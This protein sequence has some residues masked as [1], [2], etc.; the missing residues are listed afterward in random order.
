MNLSR[1]RP[2]FSLWAWLVLVGYMLTA[3][4]GIDGASTTRE[5]VLGGTVSVIV[6]LV[7]GLAFLGLGRIDLA[8]ASRPPLRWTFVGLALV[9][10]AFGRP[11]L[12][13]TL[14]HAFGID[15][16]ATP[17]AV[18]VALNLLVIACGTLLIYA[19]RSAIRRNVAG[20]RRLLAVLGQL[21]SQAEQIE[22]A[23]DAIADDFQREVR[24]PVLDALGA[25]ASRDLPPAQLAE[26]LRFVAH[27][28]V[29]PLSHQA[30]RAELEEALDEIALDATPTPEAGRLERGLLQPSRIIVAPAWLTTLVCMLVLIPAVLN[31]QGI[32]L[33]LLV[34]AGAS[35]VSYVGGLALT[36][37]PLPRR[38]VSAIIVL[39]GA[40]LV[41]AALAV[42]VLLGP[43]TVPPIIEA[44]L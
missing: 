42:W 12:V 25:L 34:I 17:V 40:H 32:P 16:V 38:P 26:E 30:S 43:L 20:R 13:T 14:Q 3:L 44:Y 1:P 28:V 31:V 18:R 21:R 8:L 23:A 9:G 39:V 6:A 7:L 15:L 35:A 41:I 27:A 36:F 29:R 22:A 33:G 2:V 5:W 19:L 24:T 4:G 11:A 10:L 37:L